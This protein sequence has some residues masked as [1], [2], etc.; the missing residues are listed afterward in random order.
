LDGLV[1]AK[2]KNLKLIVT[3]RWQALSEMP[4]S[5]ADLLC[6]GAADPSRRSDV[7]P[8]DS[9]TWQFYFGTLDPQKANPDSQVIFIALEPRTLR[10]M[11]AELI[12]EL[13]PNHGRTGQ[14]TLAEQRA[15]LA[16][17]AR[18][19]E[20][21]HGA[22]LVGRQRLETI[23]KRVG[24]RIQVAGLNYK[25][26][27]L[28]FEIAGVLPAGIFDQ[29]AIM[30]RD[31]LN[32]AVDTYPKSHGH[33][34]H[35][36]ADRSLSRVLLK[37]PDEESSGRVA[38][39]VES[40]PIFRNPTVKCETM[41]SDIATKLDFFRDLIWGLRWLVSPAVMVTMV[42][43]ISNAISISVR[44]RRP[45][46]AVLKVLGFRPV[47]L[48]GLVVGEGVLIGAA[49]GLFACTLT[50]MLVDLALSQAVSL[51]LY[52]PMQAFWWGPLLGAGAAIFGSVVPAWSA[53]TVNVAE[54]FSKVG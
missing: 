13:S 15:A 32:A 22:I 3:E 23:H 51:P 49:S 14:E 52:V 46:I 2:G 17:A 38:A 25:D 37:V 16:D 47:Q 1:A 53:T 19:M 11:M 27:N 26:I 45:E 5:Y 28:E 54:V 33:I 10:T 7:V 42:L 36:L 41:S 40:S 9:M 8:Q 4:F 34:K 21:D 18:R 30:N 50:Y 31:Y 20:A 24:E 44:E 43:V 35:P 29:L 12:E 48:L 39:Q 6:R